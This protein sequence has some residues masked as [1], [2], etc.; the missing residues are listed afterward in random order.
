M[1]EQAMNHRADWLKQLALGAIAGLVGTLA[2]QVLRLANQKWLPDTM[3]PIRQDPGAFMIETVKASLPAHTRPH[4][5][6]AVEAGAAQTLA[7]GYGLTFGALY[8]T[9]RPQ[10]G[11]PFLDGITLGLGTWAV[12]YA[13]WLPASGLM[14]P[15]W[16]QRPPQTMMPAVQHVL[17][18]VATVTAYN[19]LQER[20]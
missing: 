11:G 16:E 14:P 18:G 1:Q 6:Q 12:G 9:L 2:L 8:A 17:Y 5:P 13:G 4:L 7:L 20:L 10:G 19:W 15:L 3:P